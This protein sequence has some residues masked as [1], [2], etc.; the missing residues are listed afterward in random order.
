MLS[1]MNIVLSET[2]T[3][4]ALMESNGKY[5]YTQVFQIEF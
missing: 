1:V 3:V 2:K 4:F 5:N